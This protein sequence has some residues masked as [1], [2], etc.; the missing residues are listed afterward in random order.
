MKNVRIGLFM[1]SVL[2]VLVS[3]CKK[4][5]N[6]PFVS[7]KSRDA[8]ITA[9][10]K[11][12][13]IEG[14]SNS[15]VVTYDGAT[16]SEGGEITYKN[17]SFEMTIDKDGILTSTEVKTLNFLNSKETIESATGFWAWLSANKEKTYINLST[18][19]PFGLSVATYYIDQLKSSELVL[20]Y[21][22]TSTNAN[23]TYVTD[24]K[25]TFEK[26]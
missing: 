4:G 25:L 6:D 23:T 16:L 18:G 22:A 21:Y 8:R 13:K 15:E 20:K 7:L 26:Q 17:A 19:G 24:L 14:T 2:M 11:L 10:W 3:S 1:L 9:K 5:E 12:T